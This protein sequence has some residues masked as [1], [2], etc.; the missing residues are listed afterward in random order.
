MTI[1]LV[2]GIRIVSHHTCDA[3]SKTF[4]GYHL[5]KREKKVLGDGRV[6]WIDHRWEFVEQ[7]GREW[8]EDLGKGYTIALGDYVKDE[9]GLYRH[10]R[11]FW[12]GTPL[13]GLDADNVKV[14]LD[15]KD[16]A[17]APWT[18]EEGLIKRYPSLKSTAFGIVQSVNSM[19]TEKPHRR[20]R[21]F[22][23]F[24]RII[25]D[26]KEYHH[27]MLVL[28]HQYPIIAPVERSPAQPIYGNSREGFNG[29]DF[30]GNVQSVDE[31]LSRE[32]P[33]K[34]TY[35]PTPTEP[36][37]NTIKTD[38][39]TGSDYDGPKISLDEWL[40]K[41]NVETLGPRD[42]GGYFVRCP[43]PHA[44]G[45]YGRTDS[46]IFED[47][48]GK[49]YHCSHT[50]CRDSGK[51]KWKPWADAVVPDRLKKVARK[52][53]KK[54]TQ[55]EVPAWKVDGKFSALDAADVLQVE[56]HY[57]TLPGSILPNYYDEGVYK[58]DVDDVL[59][60]R[61]QKLLG[62]DWTPHK[63]N[64]IIRAIK[65]QTSEHFS[66]SAEFVNYANG[67]FDL[68][69]GELLQHDPK[70][71]KSIIQC[72]WRY[73]KDAECPPGTW[74]SWLDEK[75]PNKEDQ[76]VLM[77]CIGYTLRCD[78]A[79]FGKMMIL[80]GP[81]QTGKST[82]FHILKALCGIGNWTANSLHALDDMNIRFARAS[83]R[84][85]V[86]NF[87]D[88]MSY[89]AL[90]GDGYLKSIIAGGEVDGEHKGQHAFF[91]K[92]FTTLWASSNQ[93]PKS[94]DKSQALSERL[95]FFPFIIQH[96][97]NKDPDILQHLIT[98]EVMEG[99]IF[100]AM[101]ALRYAIKQKG[102]QENETTRSLR[103]EFD[104]GNNH[105]AV[106]LKTF[107]EVTPLHKKN[108]VEE[109]RVRAAYEQWVKDEE[110]DSGDVL[111]KTRFRAALKERGISRGRPRDGSSN[112]PFKFFGLREI[113]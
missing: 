11:M 68:N 45:K 46:Y 41:Y 78:A 92:P 39:R 4:A 10:K 1:T 61:I 6:Q 64:S 51:S 42:E 8:L 27:L 14:S 28:A 88:D 62:S 17:L 53:R 52:G 113:T 66:P 58:E 77:Q 9:K 29:I 18:E 112:P 96:I 36:Q 86:A 37:T 110:I 81:T 33:T 69:T 3:E 40:V 49:A 108:V 43:F 2:K 57:L 34:K 70:E 98:R 35:T 47:S 99:I 103:Q 91:F 82:L 19:H 89:R 75:L 54:K 107:Y 87:T 71:K 83:L 85:K 100:A 38:N 15:A 79:E 12:R 76:E 44:S 5:G 109:S 102:I 105:I 95:I 65:E 48:K 30:Y 56:H 16:N 84:N 111:N 7:L 55:A 97:D 50:S 32:A 73:V 104:F 101:G 94:R 74:W 21:I 90:A 13:M 80:V 31:L 106:F 20:H 23:L 93:M 24:D 67:V 72:P 26:E 59:T 60:M 22:F 25:E 63:A